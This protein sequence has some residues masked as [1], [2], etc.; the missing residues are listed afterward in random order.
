MPADMLFI[1]WVVPSQQT[2][3]YRKTVDQFSAAAA[4]NR[5]VDA[6]L[7]YIKD[8]YFPG[9]VVCGAAFC[10]SALFDSWRPKTH[11]AAAPTLPCPATEPATPPAMA[12]LMH[13]LAWAAEENASP[14]TAAQ[15]K[16][17]LMSF[18][19][20]EFGG[21]VSEGKLRHE[22]VAIRKTHHGG[23]RSGADS[24]CYQ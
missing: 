24:R 13:P 22:P 16:S 12:P 2:N 18:S 1:N 19:P 7:E 11:P 17:L 6:R 14:R 23:C 4:H 20:N 10:A 3:R 21:I 15:M 8:N 9:A 5:C